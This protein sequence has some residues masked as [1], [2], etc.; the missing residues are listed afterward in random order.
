MIE[1]DQ[2]VGAI[3]IGTT[4][5]VTLI[6]KMNE[7]GH[8]EILSIAKTESKG[9]KRGVVQNIEET[10]AAISRTVQEAELKAGEKLQEVFVGI[11]GQHIRSIK[12]RGYINRDSYDEEITRD[13]IKKLENDML[14]IPTEVGEEIIHVIPQNYIVDN[15]TGVKNPV[16]MSG[17]RLEANFHIVIA[18]IASAKNIEKCINRAGLKVKCLMLEPIAS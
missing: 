12:N 17:K 14:K 3:D 2:I 6:G 15:E 9:V 1:K 10:V 4:K 8:L 5:I 7:N 16:G 13:D 18:Q 11:A